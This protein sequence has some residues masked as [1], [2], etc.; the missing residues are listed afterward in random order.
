MSISVKGGMIFNGW[1]WINF[2]DQPGINHE[3]FD[4]SEKFKH[5]VDERQGQW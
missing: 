1:L 4:P 3:S 5:E 2:H